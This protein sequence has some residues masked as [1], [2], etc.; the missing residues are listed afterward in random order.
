MISYLNS[1][2]TRNCLCM[3]N[4]FFL[5]LHF[6]CGKFEQAMLLSK[7]MFPVR[8]KRSHPAPC[9][10]KHR[11][12]SQGTKK[13]SHS[14][15]NIWNLNKEINLLTGGTRTARIQEVELIRA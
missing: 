15:P 2:V 5:I 8:Q 13:I 14:D 6:F 12:F 11:Q 3:V 9:P 1:S 7:P 10:G 4:I